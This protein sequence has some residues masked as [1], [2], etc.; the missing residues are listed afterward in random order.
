[1][2][3]MPLNRNLWMKCRCISFFALRMKMYCLLFVLLELSLNGC[4]DSTWSVLSSLA[5]LLCCLFYVC[6]S[7]SAR[8]SCSLLLLLICLPLL[9]WT[10]R[11]TVLLSSEGSNLSV[12]IHRQL[13][14]AS[15]E[16][17]S[18]YATVQFNYPSQLKIISLLALCLVLQLLY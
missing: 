1:M 2:R 7:S 13:A 14:C 17:D 12:N 16:P 3:E 18:V 15:L 6:S 8:L 4:F 9:K 5:L 10:F 11:L